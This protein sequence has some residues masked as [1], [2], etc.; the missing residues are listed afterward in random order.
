MSPPSA[1]VSPPAGT[2]SNPRLLEKLA[3]AD[4]K[5]STDA[6]GNVVVRHGGA[7]WTVRA[8]ARGFVVSRPMRTG[9]T[10]AS[11]ADVPKMIKGGRR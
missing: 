10:A 7:D 9:I 2:A 3:K 8:E 11:E 5:F 1:P 4:L 6:D